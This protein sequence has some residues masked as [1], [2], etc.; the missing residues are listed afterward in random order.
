V[1]PIPEWEPDEVR[2]IVVCRNEALR[3]PFMLKYHFELGVSRVL[4]VDNDSTDGTR[5]LA[6]ADPRIHV[7]T[8]KERYKGPL[9]WQE[10]LLRRFAVGRWCLVLDADELFVYPQMDRMPLPALAAAL[11]AEDAAALHCLF[12]EMFSR[13]PIGQVGYRPGDDLR[14][15]APWFDAEGYVRKKYRRVFD[16][17]APETIFMGGTRGRMFNAEFGCSKYPFFKYAP[18]LFLRRGLHT[19]EGAPIAAAQ[20]AVLHFKYL[21]D[22]KEKAFREAAR[23]VYWNASA[24]YKAYAERFR[25]EGDFSLWHPGAKR[26]EGW[27]QLAD[28]GLV[29]GSPAWAAAAESK[30]GGA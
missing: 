2:M 7:W 11:E 1:R 8:S 18:G 9:Y 24:E 27:R 21:Q 28:L 19:I 6:A 12:L 13:E 4:L 23:G 22:F 14:T 10:P 20:G 15:A 26:L 3:L 5:D 17:P 30:R 25:R 29:H 16:G